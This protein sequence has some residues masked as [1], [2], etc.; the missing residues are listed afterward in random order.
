MKSG[1]KFME[2]DSQVKILESQIRE[3]YGRVVWTHKTQEKCC[4]I[5]NRR[6]DLIKV[7]QI[8]LS[9]V[10]TSGI[11]ISILGQNNFVAIISAI[12]STLLLV[13]NALVKN[14]D[15]GET[16]QKHA[17]CATHLWDVREKY[18]SLLVDIKADILDM[19]QIKQRRDELQKE[20]FDIYKGSP[21]S[22]G[23]AY[24]EATKALK[25]NEELTF[26]DKEIDLLLPKELRKLQKEDN[27]QLSS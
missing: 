2:Q 7:T 17:A 15:L 11:F 21:R 13:L 24:S 26:S 1:E 16:A 6:N 4:D 27:L 20:L 14:Y 18:L 22:I 23:K 12:F 8:I 3:C 10:T 5:L 19:E 25:Q 9:A